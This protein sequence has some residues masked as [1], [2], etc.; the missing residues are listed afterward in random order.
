[1]WRRLVLIFV[2]L[3]MGWNREFLFLLGKKCGVES[4]LSV[5]SLKEKIGRE[6][7]LLPALDWKRRS[8]YT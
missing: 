8:P 5:M 7:I 1:M 6:R 3:D 2:S 4:K